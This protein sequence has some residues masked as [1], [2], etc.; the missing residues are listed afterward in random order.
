MPKLAPVYLL[1][2][3]IISCSNPKEQTKSIVAEGAELQ[4]VADQFKFTEG[5]ASDREGNVYFTDQPNDAIWKWSPSDG[6][7]LF[8]DS[9]GRANG[10]YV[11]DQ[12]YLLACA[13]EANELWRINLADKTHEVLLKGW[14]GMKYNGPNDLWL[15]A[16]GGIYFTDPFYKRV[17]WK[18]TSM[19]QSNCKV[20]YLP[21][22]D[23]TP[24]VQDSTLIRPNGIIGSP[25]QK[26]LYVA[27][28]TGKKLYQYHIG[29]DGQLENKRLF[30]DTGSDGM[31]I[32]N[33]GNI[34]VTGDGVTV[35]DDLGIKIHHIP[36]DRSWTANVTFG[37]PDQDILFITAMNSVF[38]LKMNV[39]GVRWQ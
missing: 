25:D 5:P 1:V 17:Y 12:G 39:K 38:T 8:M 9:S 29:L 33:Q 27:D 3:I 24:I 30:A 13:D 6:L 14:K 19:Q 23:T 26:Y 34:Y 35:Y 28:N 18:D 36:V 2:L 4:L 20:F 10:L 21:P 16:K 31:T 37:G 11:D 15:D 7:T 32:D 22:G